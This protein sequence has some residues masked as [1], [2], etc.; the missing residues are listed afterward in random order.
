VAK[1]CDRGGAQPQRQR[2]R[3]E[4]RGLIA[5]LVRRG[6][7]RSVSKTPAVELREIGVLV[8]H[9][10]GGFVS[11]RRHC[12]VDQERTE[13]LRHAL[14]SAQSW[15]QPIAEPS[16]RGGGGQRGEI[17]EQR[18]RHCVASRLGRR[19]IF[20]EIGSGNIL[21]GYENGEEIAQRCL[22]RRVDGEGAKKTDDCR[23]ESTPN[24]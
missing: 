24:Q 21:I 14:Y 15:I 19:F 1:S 7:Q 13:A 6:L 4:W 17:D 10:N 5:K 12:A 9:R 18:P 11:A 20:Y 16:R 2:I 23:D 8:G 22:C 3:I